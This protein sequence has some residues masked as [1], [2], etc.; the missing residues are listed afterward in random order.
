MGFL[1]ALHD[2]NVLGAF[3][4]ADVLGAIY[5]CDIGALGDVSVLR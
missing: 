5:I 3:G 2:V 1:G 4:D